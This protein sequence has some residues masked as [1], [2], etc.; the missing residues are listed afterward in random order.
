MVVGSFHTEQSCRM[1][2]TQ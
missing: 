2:V 1:A